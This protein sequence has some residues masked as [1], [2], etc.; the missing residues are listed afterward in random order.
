MRYLLDLSTISEPLRS[1]TASGVMGRFREYNGE[2]DTPAS[3]W[4]EMPSYCT[5]IPLCS[6]GQTIKCYIET[7]VLEASPILYCD[8]AV[9]D[10]HALV[11]ACLTST[12]ISAPFAVDPLAPIAHVNDFCHYISC[13]QLQGSPRT[14][15]AEL[16]VS[17]ANGHCGF[18]C[19]RY[20][21]RVASM[22]ETE[23]HRPRHA[24]EERPTG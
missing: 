5:C 21:S 16:D 11:G 14:T 1:R 20:A 9:A 19:Q 13:W 6:R 12:D 17:T 2:T 3:V 10:W 18:G 15:V 8:T 4:Q 24:S 23:S 7:A 22:V